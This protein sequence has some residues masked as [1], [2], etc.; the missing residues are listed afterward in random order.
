MGKTLVDIPVEI[1]IEIFS[2]INHT[3]RLSIQLTCSYFNK[4]LSDEICW[5]MAFEFKFGRIF[6]TPPSWKYEYLEKTRVN[7]FWMSALKAT[8]TLSRM[9][10]VSHLAF[11]HK[12]DV[13]IASNETGSL[14]LY[15]PDSG[16]VSNLM[17]FV[18]D[19]D[20]Q[21][22][23]P[24]S[25]LALSSNLLVFGGLR[26]VVIF[27]KIPSFSR[28]VLSVNSAVTLCKIISGSYFIC[29]HQNGM[30]SLYNTISGQKNGEFEGFTVPLTD[31]EFSQKYLVGFAGD[32]IIVW[33]I[34]KYSSN[35]RNLLYQPI[36]TFIV[37]DITGIRMMMD[38]L[39]IVFADEGRIMKC[40][41]IETQKEILY[42]GANLHPITASTVLDKFLVT[43]DCFGLIKIWQWT[44]LQG[45][46]HEFQFIRNEDRVVQLH[47]TPMI[48]I[49]SYSRG[50]IMMLDP[51]NLTNLRK[52]NYRLPNEFVGPFAINERAFA[53]AYVNRVASLSERE[54][55]RPTKKQK[56]PGIAF[57]TDSSNSDIREEV[58][59]VKAEML[60]RKLD[61]E[62]IQKK[63]R[64]ING[65]EDDHGMDEELLVEYAKFLS[66]EQSAGHEITEEEMI[67]IA[68][69]LS[70]E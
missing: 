1:L 45:L 32:K 59:M 68:L 28:Q 48:L 37:N 24:N 57:K 20:R 5:K 61:T 21:G 33:A 43:G 4:V 16:K 54:P 49:A 6:A 30:I 18:D 58:A 15:N 17:D 7:R 35:D 51:S 46:K 50:C 64:S 25:N 26:N 38:H 10:I 13:A 12:G 3:D 14:A 31:I 39:V 47:F 53:F 44:D 56:R 8:N 70:L 42:P 52:I 36:C 63:V 29:C 22:I 40:I 19:W 27:I 34:P 66:Q 67:E 9:G 11:T 69:A 60:T 62:R 23:S 2:M 55:K 65:S 41:N